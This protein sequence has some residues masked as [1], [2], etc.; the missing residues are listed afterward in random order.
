MTLKRA[1][2]EGVA[3]RIRPVLAAPDDIGTRG[4]VDFVLA[5]WMVHEVE[6]TSRFFV[7][8]FSVLKEQGKMLIVEPKMHVGKQRFRE[9][10]QAARDAGFR[11]SDAPAI[12]LSRA[13][14]LERD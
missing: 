13:V 3:L 14:L 10:V 4:P 7:Q 11:G 9:I 5:F 6:D 12:R 1:K 8:A 2:K